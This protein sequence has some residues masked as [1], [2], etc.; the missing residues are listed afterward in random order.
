[1]QIFTWIAQDRLSLREVRQRLQKQRIPTRTGKP[2]WSPAALTNLL[3]NTTYIGEARYGK[4]RVVARR[5]QLRPRRHQPAVPRR[6]YSMSKCSESAVAIAVPALV[7]AD[8][9]AQAGEQLDENLRRARVRRTGV[10]WL[11]QGLLVCRFCGYAC[12]GFHR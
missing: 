8:L 12:T 3:R 1:R 5:P 9:F 6:P 4:M 10:Q 7:S 2:R 11:L